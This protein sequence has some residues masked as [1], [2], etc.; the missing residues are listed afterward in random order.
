MQY[1]FRQVSRIDASRGLSISGNEHTF[2]GELVTV[3]IC[4][5]CGMTHYVP[6]VT[7]NLDFV[8]GNCGAGFNKIVSKPEN[9]KAN[10]G[11]IIWANTTMEQ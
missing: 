9:T 8:C 1:R 4:H 3:V 6:T 2:L 10:V 5:G 7:F 11:K